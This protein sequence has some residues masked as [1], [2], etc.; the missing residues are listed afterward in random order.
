MV[1]APQ[2]PV[3]TGVQTAQAPMAT[4][5]TIEAAVERLHRENRTTEDETRYTQS[6][7]DILAAQNIETV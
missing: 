7:L 1:V 2:I 4:A 3:P 5:E 6:I